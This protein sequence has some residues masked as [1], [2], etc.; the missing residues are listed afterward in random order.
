MVTEEFLNG[1]QFTYIFLLYKIKES[2]QNI[3]KHKK[4]THSYSFK[5]RL[6]GK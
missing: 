3:L 1:F 6:L 2:D 5:T 4:Y